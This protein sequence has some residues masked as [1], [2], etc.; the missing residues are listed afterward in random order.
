[1]NSI[2]VSS[3]PSIFQI[4]RKKVPFR[5]TIRKPTWSKYSKSALDSLVDSNINLYGTYEEPYLKAA[6][7]I[8][9]CEI[10]TQ[11]MRKYCR[12]MEGSVFWLVDE[13]F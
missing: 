8:M 7:I 4:F 1:M 9:L 11:T 3:L 2:E 13:T 6:D 10:P 5:T 12:K